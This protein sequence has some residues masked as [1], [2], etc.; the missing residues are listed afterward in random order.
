M[1]PNMALPA[2]LVSAR[3]PGTLPKTSMARLISLLA[4]PPLLIKRPARMKNGT[5]SSVK[6]SMP[7]TIFWADTNIPKVGVRNAI[8]VISADAMIL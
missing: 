4:M 7:P 5:A 6:L 1:E 8:M 2:M 3:D